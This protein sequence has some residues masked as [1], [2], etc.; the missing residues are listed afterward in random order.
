MALVAIDGFDLYN[1]VGAGTGIGGKWV[2]DATSG[3]LL[4]VSGRVGGQALFVGG[5]NTGTA[6]AQVHR[7]LPSNYTD[8]GLGFALKVDAIASMNATTTNNIFAVLTDSSASVQ[9]GLAVGNDGKL[10][11]YRL[12]GFN[13]GT[14]LG[15]TAAGVMVTGTWQYV[16]WGVT[17]SDTVGVF[18]LKVD[19]V[20]VLN[21]TAQ[22]TRNG[23]P[24]TVNRIY[25]TQL[26]N[27]STFSVNNINVD[28]LYIVDSATTLGERR[29]QT[30]YPTSDVAQ[31]FARS[32]GSTNYTLVDETLANGDT[33]YV[34]GSTVGDVDTY[35]FGDVTGTPT[36]IDAVQVSAFAEKTDV[37]ARQIALQ[38][39][40]GATTSDGA[41]FALTTA[42]AKYERIAALDPNTSGAWSAS[43][44]N[45][46]QG[47]PK[48]T[49]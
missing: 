24:T 1:G 20:S 47:G 34:Q 3:N 35:G 16:E 43:S 9:V 26:L 12:T 49:V 4:L 22:D 39:K 40:S 38:L 13:A 46:L 32:T 42:Y 10:H 21:L 44:V 19:G 33:D 30:C 27:N 17:I 37:T 36:T 18:T 15:S 8:I 23:A 11:A 7:V 48:V 6:N 29:V 31:G 14:L 5:Q 2:V 28:D 45:A 41:N 25:F